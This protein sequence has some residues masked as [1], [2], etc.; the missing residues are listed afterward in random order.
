VRQVRRLIRAVAFRVACGRVVD[1]A[2]LALVGAGGSAIALR[3]VER[4]LGVPMPWETLAWV[5][6]IGAVGLGVIWAMARLPRADRVARLIDE[7]GEL[8]ETLSTALSLERDDGPWARAIVAEAEARASSVRPAIIAPARAPRHWAWLIGVSAALGAGWFLVPKVD[9]V[10][11][12]AA[13]EAR[14]QAERE[15]IEARAEADA[16]DARIDALVAALGIDPA[17][18]EPPPSPE[19]EPG[20]PSPERLELAQLQRLTDLRDRLDELRRSESAQSLE[21]AKDLLEQL[22][23]PPP[24]PMDELARRMARGEFDQAQRALEALREQLEQGE[25]SEEQ[26]AAM[27]AQLEQL[28]EQM[29]RLSETRERVADELEQAGLSREQ[30]ERLAQQ[31]DAEAMERALREAN[32]Q[33]SEAQRRE[34]ANKLAGQ[35]KACDA[36]GGMGGAMSRMAQAMQDGGMGQDGAAAMQDLADALSKLEMLSQELAALDAAQAQALAELEAL[37]EC[38]GQ[39]G[40]AQ[41]SNPGQGQG[42]SLAKTAGQ[43][44]GSGGRRA[45]TAT[46]HNEGE[47]SQ[48]PY[49]TERYRSPM[50]SRQGPIIASRFVFGEQVIGEARAGFS[51]AVEQSGKA[52][53][54]ALE[55]RRVPREYHDAVKRYF[56]RLEQ[57]ARDDAPPANPG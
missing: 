22:R 28:A 4:L 25:L 8:R 31:G 45:G 23:R 26:R 11:Q 33:M 53:A 51:D 17:L 18:L 57:T 39:E 40:W 2:V 27:R 19:G 47:A 43:S 1:H 56:G 48:T 32:P 15:L 52:A 38:M 10:G 9:V 20:R 13:A 7:R 14:A 37:A 21:T 3:L 41:C 30:A 35:C 54:E 34:M 36:A 55:S 12:L 5:L 46:A 44:P 24:G 6:P 29:Q 42:L 49:D 16:R 50:Q